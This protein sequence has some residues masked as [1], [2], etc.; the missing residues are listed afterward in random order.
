M[1]VLK[2]RESQF[3]TRKPFADRKEESGGAV[4]ES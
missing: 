4:Y 2:R 1:L 3:Y